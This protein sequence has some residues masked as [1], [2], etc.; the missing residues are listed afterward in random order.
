MLKLTSFTLLAVLLSGCTPSTASVKIDT[1]LDGKKNSIQTICL[2]G[3]EYYLYD[4]V[5]R[6]GLAVVIDKNTL[7][8]KLCLL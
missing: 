8:P 7:Q 2:N 3:V 1:N 6:G 5:N 4:Y